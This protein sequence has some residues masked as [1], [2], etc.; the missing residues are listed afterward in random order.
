MGNDEQT[1]TVANDTQGIDETNAQS[2]TE[3]NAGEQNDEGKAV[4]TVEKLQKRLSAVSEEKN[5]YKAQ[6]E[7]LTAQNA[8]LQQQLDDRNNGKSVKELSEE[9]QAQQ[10]EQAKDEEIKR[11]KAQLARTQAMQDTNEVLK[12]QGYNVPANV[13]DL[14]VSDDNEKTLA[15]TKALLAF[16]EQVQADTRANVLRGN[17]NAPKRTGAPVKTMTKADIMSIKDEVQRQQ[18]IAENIDLFRKK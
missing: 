15:N 11:L 8:Q 1:Q 16:M 6:I 3:P 2:Q 4:R 7:E 5:S 17:S 10:A 12:E 9:E 18:A 13:L 14:I